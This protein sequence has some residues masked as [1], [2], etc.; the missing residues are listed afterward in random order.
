MLS[1]ILISVFGLSF[2]VLFFYLLWFWL[3]F[4]NHKPIDVKNDTT[5]PP[6]SIVICARNE[7]WNLKNNLPLI[8]DQNYPEFEVIVVDDNSSDETFFICKDFQQRYSNLEIVKLSEN[9]NFFRGKK[10]PLSIGI[11]SAKHKHLILTDADCYPQSLVWLQHMASCFTE[12]K[13]VVLGYGKYEKKAGFLNKLIRFETL[14][15][16]LN[17]FSFALAH[18]PYMGVGRNLAYHKNLFDTNKGFSRH[19]TIPS[20][21]DDLFVNEVANKNNTCISVHPD[22][23]TVSSPHTTWRSWWKQKRRHLSTSKK[24]KFGDKLRLSLH[25]LFL[26]LFYTSFVWICFLNIEKNTFYI[27]NS[28]LIIRVI[29]FWVIVKKTSEKLEEKNLF[30]FSLFFEIYIILLQGVIL[31]ANGIS[32]QGKWK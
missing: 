5:L 18:V 14:Y 29:F 12:T 10:F 13:K 27:I 22:S 25:P 21:D 8:L 1:L 31:I 32:K 2:I 30:I 20:G 7:E 24:Y 17:Y 16:A 11:R 28:L 19:Y 23:F 3:R 4:I 9:V 6:L 26:V 15:T